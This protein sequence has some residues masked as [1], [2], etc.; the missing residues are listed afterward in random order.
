MKKPGI[1]NVTKIFEKV[2]RTL[3]KHAFIAS[4]VLI[5]LASAIGA[6]IFYKYSIQVAEKEIE[7]T[8]KRLWL[9]EDALQKV[10][11][12][13]KEREIRFKQVELKKYSDLFGRPLIEEDKELTE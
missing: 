4:L 6:L 12:E 7:F 10:L 8:E 11:L 9:E 3:G 2:F 1:K 5:F 13:I